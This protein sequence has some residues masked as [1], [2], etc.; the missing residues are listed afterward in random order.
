[1]ISQSISIHNMPS[2]YTTS[3]Y[4]EVNEYELNCSVSILPHADQLP[5]MFTYVPLQK[6][7]LVRW[8][9]C[10]INY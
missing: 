3:A 1:M 8:F 5:N 4:E 10:S 6:N 9:D 7:S 2:L